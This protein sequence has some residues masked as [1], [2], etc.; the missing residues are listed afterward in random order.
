MSK[1]ILATITNVKTMVNAWPSKPTTPT[2]AN[3]IR[4]SKENSANFNV[5]F[6]GIFKRPRRLGLWSQRIHLLQ[7]KFIYFHTDHMVG[8]QRD[9]EV[10]EDRK[11]GGGDKQQR[12]NRNRSGGNKR[13]QANKKCKKQ[14]YRDYYIE[15][16]GCRSK[17]PYKMAKCVASDG[18][19]DSNNCVPTRVKTRKIRFVC[20]DGSTSRKEV[21]MVRKCGRNKKSWLGWKSWFS[22]TSVQRI[23]FSFFST[24]LFCQSKS[25]N[26]ESVCL[27][28][29]YTC[30]YYN[31]DTGNIIQQHTPLFIVIYDKNNTTQWMNSQ[32]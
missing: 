8:S 4:I 26:Y 28:E 3:V 30:Y 19:T 9:K 12:R 23:F 11:S 13:Q 5:S 25:F 31:R 7:L 20:P 17:R 14:R 21:E 32:Q 29:V 15:E 16:H 22:N 6:N 1:V 2:N 18:S 10:N 27:I 24:S